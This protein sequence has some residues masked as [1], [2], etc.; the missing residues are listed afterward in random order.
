MG[1]ALPAVGVLDGPEAPEGGAADAG[2]EAIAGQGDPGG[3][4]QVQRDRPPARRSR[5]PRRREAG[6]RP[7][8]AGRRASPSS[9]AAGIDGTVASSGRGAPGGR[10]ARRLSAGGRRRLGRRPESP[11]VGLDQRR[12]KSMHEAEPL[13]RRLGQ[14]RAPAAGRR[15]AARTGRAGRT[16]ASAAAD[17]GW[18]TRTARC[19]SAAAGRRWPGCTGRCGG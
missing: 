13:L 1:H 7:G 14:R 6:G 9:I 19:R 8:A 12:T 17:T 2:Q 18:P 5:G 16:C 3:L 11:R 15:A 4:R 10:G